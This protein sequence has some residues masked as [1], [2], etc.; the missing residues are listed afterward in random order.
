MTLFGSGKQRV[1]MSRLDIVGRATVAVQSDPEAY[2]NRP[3]YFADYTLST[4]ELLAL[5]KEVSPGWKIE[6]VPI[7]NLLSQGLQK[8]DEDSANGVED[9]LNSAAYMMLG[10]YDIFAEGNRY[11][12]DFKAK[13]EKDLEKEK[14]ELKQDLQ[15]VLD[16]SKQYFSKMRTT[17]RYSNQSEC[18]LCL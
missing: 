15:G 12:A 1:S 5:L 7:E 18:P 17:E 13:T 4:I 11:G 16:G 6:N 9:R 2:A 14:E 8:W 3:A 10:T